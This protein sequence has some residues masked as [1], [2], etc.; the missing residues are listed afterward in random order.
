[1]TSYNTEVLYFKINASVTIRVKI[2]LNKHI[3][4]NVYFYLTLQIHFAN[5]TF[6]F[7]QNDCKLISFE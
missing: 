1:M 2:T 5:N 7:L 6:V 4:E 3:L